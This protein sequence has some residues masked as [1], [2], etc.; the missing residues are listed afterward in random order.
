MEDLCVNT[1]H[2]VIIVEPAFRSVWLVESKRAPWLIRHILREEYTTCPHCHSPGITSE[3]K[4]LLTV[5][6]ECPMC[7]KALKDEDIVP[8]MEPDVEIKKLLPMKE[9]EDENMEEGSIE[10]EDDSW[11]SNVREITAIVITHFLLPSNAS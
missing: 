8:S 2:S 6:N 9:Q 5:A 10:D 11:L 7:N 1:K 4:R 3:F